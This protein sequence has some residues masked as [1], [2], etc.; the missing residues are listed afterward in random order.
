M[1]R[2]QLGGALLDCLYEAPLE[3]KGW[4]SFVRTLEC[5]L[6]GSVAMLCMPTPSN[7]VPGWLVAP[8]LDLEFVESY[9]QTW[10]RSD[11]W[12][13]EA[14]ALS[15]GDVIVREG[16][17]GGEPLIETSFYR[18]W[19]QPQGLLPDPLLG[20]VV[21]RDAH[22]P[23][24]LIRVF[25]RS[26][27][28]PG[29]LAPGLLRALMPHLRRALR[30]HFASVRL[31]AERDA[32]ATA[33]ERLPLGL[34]L[35]DRRYR[36]HVTNRCAERLLAQ[37]DGIVLDRD[38]LH[39]TRPEDEARL[40]RV[41]ADAFEG[42]QR[43]EAGGALLL[44][45]SA[46]RRPLRASVSRVPSGGRDGSEAALAVV[47]VSDPEAEVELP[48]DVLSRFHALTGA[49]SALVR[50]LAN[51]RSLREAAGR[52]KI[53]EGT[54]RQRLVQVFEKTGT[55][56]QSALVRLVLTGPESLSAEE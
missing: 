17:V 3:P 24:S 11:P 37:R 8:S 38:G 43:L 50:E 47:F 16:W 22:R 26:D 45:R 51:G 33:A 21:D 30:M 19:M 56:R 39:A 12:L 55:G 13:R 53:T 29:K 15:V 4:A 34:I 41:L 31:A 35:I 48:A 6:D 9:A 14:N 10:F 49:E 7:E 2:S 27:T 5:S 1:V 36:V 18:E 32:L 54:A 46:G 23:S 28:R 25:Q 44:E 20:G 40:R 42:T 52:L